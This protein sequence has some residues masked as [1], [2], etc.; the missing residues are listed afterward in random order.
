M[1]VN[2]G[3]R[4]SPVSAPR[5]LVFQ[6][7]SATGKGSLSGATGESSRVLERIGVSI[8]AE[9]LTKS[10]TRTYRTAEEVRLYPSERITFRHLEGPLVYSE[11]EFSLFDRGS[12]TE[13]RYKGEME[14]RVRLM[15]VIGWLIAMVCVRPEYKIVIRKHMHRL[16][17]A[18]EARAARSHVFHHASVP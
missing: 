1:R 17:A 12:R 15:P 2:L 3:A 13:L 18:A 6:M 16:K 8:I 9:F 7:L 11:K 4:V 10:D 5:A 14:C